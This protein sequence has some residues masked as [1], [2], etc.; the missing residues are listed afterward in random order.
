MP[1]FIKLLG[2]IELGAGTLSSKGRYQTKKIAA[3]AYLALARRSVRRGE[4]AALLWPD[5]DERRARRSLNQL[6]LE[7]RKDYGPEVILTRGEEDIALN[8]AVVACDAAELLRFA[9]DGQH[10]LVV[11]RFGG[12]LMPG[13][14]ASEANEYNDWLERARLSVRTV[15]ADALW[16][17]AETANDDKV[18]AGLL[19]RCMGLRPYD[20]IV[21]RRLMTAMANSGN[22]AQAIAV[23]ESYRATAKE[24]LGVSPAAETRKAA[25]D[26]ARLEDEEEEKRLPQDSKAPGAERSQIMPA[27]NPAV[28][29]ATKPGRGRKILAGVVLCGCLAI[30]ARIGATARASS[31]PMTDIVVR[32]FEAP[33]RDAAVAA[34]LSDALASNLSA[35]SSIVV[36]RGS[37]SSTFRYEIVGRISTTSEVIAGTAQIRDRH[38][39]VIATTEIVSSSLHGVDSV[40]AQL[41]RVVTDKWYEWHPADEETT[42]L[43]AAKRNLEN[44]RAD[45]SRGTRTPTLVSLAAASAQLD[46]IP[47]ARRDLAW[48]ATSAEVLSQKAW[49]SLS[50]DRDSSIKLFGAAAAVMR[51]SGQTQA[52]PLAAKYRSYQWM[53]DAERGDILLDSASTELSRWRREYASSGELWLESARVYFAQGE[54]GA[55]LSAFDRARG[56]QQSL[57]NDPSVSLLLFLS[58]FNAREDDL[59]IAECDRI[60]FTFKGSWP[61][62]AC[63]ALA[64]AWAGATYDLAQMSRN[65]LANDPPH[66]RESLGPRV[67]ALLAAARARH[68]SAGAVRA[69][70]RQV[71][72]GAD[73][74][75]AACRALAMGAAGHLREALAIRDRM[76]RSPSGKRT[77]QM[78][79]RPFEDLQRRLIAN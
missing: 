44:A 19:E 69:L 73:L 12:E 79:S 71:E 46:S 42:H 34:S 66:A 61:A 18:R 17:L 50:T 43:R 67:E 32:N 72:V 10:A 78:Y 3:L 27:L 21:L 54:F 8:T 39:R 1:V 9:E 2:Q 62:A 76:M 25:A 40:G 23:Y 60:R 16:R 14:I 28:T 13:F 49:W 41:A 75:L 6:L 15:V 55:A 29:H 20:E 36:A 70:S 11:E 5:T 57:M 26:I 68:N 31:V 59:A 52:Y 56:L 77:L 51:G 58:A 53:V 7:L 38:G 30:G 45:Y 24:R 35:D 37:R 74:D 22:R 65:P 4:L 48:S 33:T 64:V 47:P 63:S